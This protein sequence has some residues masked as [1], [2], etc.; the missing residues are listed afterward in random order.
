MAS[1][2]RIGDTDRATETGT[3]HVVF[4]AAITQK[5]L[6]HPDLAFNP[7]IHAPPHPNKSYT[8][9]SRLYL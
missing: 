2:L 5:L 8:A 4:G 9:T 1:E 3:S 6:L 7:K